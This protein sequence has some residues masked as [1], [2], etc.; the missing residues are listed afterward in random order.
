[1]PIRTSLLPP[2]VVLGVSQLQSFLFSVGHVLIEK[3]HR[4]SSQ[5]LV[6]SLGASSNA[7]F[8]R[9]LPLGL[10]HLIIAAFIQVLQPFTQPK[11][12]LPLHWGG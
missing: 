6:E 9:K 5:I 11:Y 1:M 4:F 8:S 3:V 10:Q 12:C 2:K 7:T